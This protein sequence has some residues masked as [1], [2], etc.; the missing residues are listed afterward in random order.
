MLARDGQQQPRSSLPRQ[1]RFRNVWPPRSFSGTSEITGATLPI[2]NDGESNRGPRVARGPSAA[3]ARLG[4]DESEFKDQEYLIR[5]GDDHLD[6]AGQ[7]AGHFLCRIRLPGAI[8]RRP[9]V[10]ARRGAMVL[11]KTD[12]LSVRPSEITVSRLRLA[13]RVRR[14]GTG[15]DGARAGTPSEQSRHGFV[16]ASLRVGGERMPAVIRCTATTI[17]S[18]SRTP[19]APRVCRRASRMVAQATRQ[20]SWRSTAGSPPQLCF[21]S[22]AW[23]IRC[24]GTPGNTLT[25]RG[26]NRGGNGGRFLCHGADGPGGPGGWCKCSAPDEIDQKRQT[27]NSFDSNGKAK[28]TI[29]CVRQSV[30]RELSNPSRQV[31]NR[32]SPTPATRI[33]RARCGWSRTFRCRCACTRGTG[34][35]L[36]AARMNSA[37]IVTG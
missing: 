11:S 16:L 33:A 36:D 23:W 5:A 13:L 10:R 4:L 6:P 25:F 17:A 26:S 9:L 21:S 19:I 35:F 32:P 37:S 8:L 1:Y 14:I 18:G 24:G 34:G 28:A 30:A 3:T 12:S 22:K 2:K 29:V 15:H 31:P 27:E 20:A 7:G